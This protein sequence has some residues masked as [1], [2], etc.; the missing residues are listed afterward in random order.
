[1]K[2]SFDEKCEE[3]YQSFINNKMP[4]APPEIIFIR[5][6]NC[7]VEQTGKLFTPKQKET[8]KPAFNVIIGIQRK[9]IPIQP[10]Y[11]AI[12]RIINNT[13]DPTYKKH[14]RIIDNITDHIEQQFLF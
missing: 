5:L 8:L 14:N 6:K 13:L 10:G 1:M 12:H 4:S 11:Q 9:L 3:V 2:Q 7:I